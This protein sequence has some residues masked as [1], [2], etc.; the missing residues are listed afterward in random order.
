MPP[1]PITS[2]REKT[3]RSLNESMTYSKGEILLMIICV[4]LNLEVA[5]VVPLQNAAAVW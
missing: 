1:L 4:D 2:S 3:T 5:E